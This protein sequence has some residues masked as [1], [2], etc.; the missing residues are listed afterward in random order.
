MTIRATRAPARAGLASSLAIAAALAAAPGIA[1][2]QDASSAD[3]PVSADI[4]VTGTLIRG[5]ASTV[6]S[7]SRSRWARPKLQETAAQSSNEL[8]ASIPQVT[9]YFNR[10]PLADLGGAAAV[11][12]IQIS[13]PNIRNI[14]PNNAS[15][16]ATL[17]LVDGHRIATAGVNQASVDPDLIPTGAIERVEVVTEGGSSIYGADAVAGVINFITRKRFDGIKIDGHY[18]TARKYWQ[19]DAAATAG[20]IWDT[21]SAYVSYTYTKSDALYGRERSFIHNLD[22]SALPYTG[23]DR[24]C[25]NPNLAVNTV[26]T[27]FGATIASTNYAAPGFARNTFNACDES[28]DETYIP[29]AE[30]HG[31][32]AGLTQDFGDRTTLDAR[33]YWGQRKT[34]SSGDLTG[35]VTVTAANPYAAASLPAGLTLGLQPF[36]IFGSPVVN[37]AAVSFNLRPLLGPDAQYASTQ[38]REYGANA[39]LKHDLTDD[40]Q[41]RALAN[42]SQSDSRYDLT[43]INTARLNAAGSASTAATAFNPFN[44][45]ANNSALIAD[46]I[47]SEIAGQAK[48]Q[49]LNFR[50]IAE[51]KLFDLPGGD[52]RLAIGYEFMHDKLQQRFQSGIRIGTLGSFPFSSYKRSVHSGFGELRLPFVSDGNGGSMLTVSG[53]ARYDHYS[54]FGNTFNPK[55]GVTFKP[56]EGFVLRGN[57][58]TSF[59]APT[60]LDQ[61][62]SA[63][64]TFSAFPFVPFAKPGETAPPGAYTVA[65]QGSRPNLKPQEADTWSVGV[66]VKPTQGLRASINYYDVKFRNIIGTPTANSGIFTDFPDNVATA[67]GGFTAAQLRAYAAQAAGGAAVAEGLISGGTLVYE[68]VDFRVGNYGI[69]HVSGV[70]F[71][72]NADHQTGFGSIDLS[73]SGNLPLRREQQASATSATVDQLRTENPELYLQASLGAT[74]GAFRAQATVNHTDGYNITPTASIPVQK[75]VGAFDTVD[76]FFKY[77]VLGE[78]V[79]LRDLSFTVNIDN[80][81][82]AKPPVLRR[83]NPAELGFAN[84]FTFGRMFIVG[85]SKKF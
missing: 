20:K 37:Q 11:N 12:Q 19:W 4:V 36:Q 6:G 60:P 13:R 16:A 51:G 5:S 76:L 73:V 63:R 81:F 82:N 15:S 46:L 25:A 84:G 30:R 24:T 7:N 2:A 17:I 29:R 52:A 42:W 23:R 48:D 50:L 72:L 61:L 59:T 44:V 43:D 41:L 10:V 80:V 64:N 79:L 54:D 26:L 71:S 69:V 66:D 56:V 74:I 58:G 65:L 67:T 53:S 28:Q 85:V 1:R 57:W 34:R 62:G 77:D 32:L 49:L 21:G 40:W 9:N 14:S 47:D 45:T 83:N 22:Y 39:E 35:T 18:G 55:L 8:L 75:R 38:I 33:A 27:A 68:F 31:V 78:S 70:D 3:E